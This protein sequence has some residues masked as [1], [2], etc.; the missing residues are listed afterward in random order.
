MKLK[1]LVALLLAVGLSSSPM[2]FAKE[3]KQ[4]VHDTAHTM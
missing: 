3:A 1:S 4:Q 2:A